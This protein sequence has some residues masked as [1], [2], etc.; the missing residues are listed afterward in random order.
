MLG[1]AARVQGAC[2][3]L[4][5]RA[6]STISGRIGMHAG[7]H[8]EALGLPPTATHEQVRLA[9]LEK[10]QLEHPDKNPG[11]SDAQQRFLKVQAA[12]EVL[13]GKAVYSPAP[14]EEQPFEDEHTQRMRATHGD[15]EAIL[16]AWEQL[17]QTAREDIEA[18]VAPGARWGV[19]QVRPV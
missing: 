8:F 4:R 10:V 12:W 16:A 19:D 13:S 14:Q 3:I 18:G 15:H 5:R 7:W 2:A 9:Y 17:M 6:A 1:A 11:D